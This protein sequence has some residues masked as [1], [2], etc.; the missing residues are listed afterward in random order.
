MAIVHAAVQMQIVQ[1]VNHN[2]TKKTIGRHRFV[3]RLST[4]VLLSTPAEDLVSFLLNLCGENPQRR[5]RLV[6]MTKEA[7]ARFGRRVVE[8]NL[9]ARKL[10]A[11]IL[12]AG[13][14]A[15]QTRHSAEAAQEEV[16]DEQLCD[17]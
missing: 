8:G 16:H 17:K 14:C 2:F 15:A 1:I 13:R 7:L 6:S 12:T 3:P 5:A 10:H 11:R 4:T 9:K